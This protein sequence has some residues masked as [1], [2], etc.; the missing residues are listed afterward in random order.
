MV[1][2]AGTRY[3]PP[4]ATSPTRPAIPVAL[5]LDP[6]VLEAVR[7]VDQSLLD[8][9]LALSPLE[10]LRACHRAAVALARFRHEAP[11]RG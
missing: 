9:S 11:G 7:D 6:L 1:S 8:W 5:E 4:M 2:W 10:R 3:P